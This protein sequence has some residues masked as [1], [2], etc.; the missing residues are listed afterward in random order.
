MSVRVHASCV[1]LGDRGVLLTGAAGAGKSTAALRL[2]ALGAE[3]VADDQVILEARDG[4]LVA[5]APEATAG[6]IEARGVG[7]LSLPHRDR[8]A[9]AVVVDLD[10]IESRR[11][12]PGRE[13][14]IEDVRLPLVHGRDLPDLAA[15]LVAWLARGGGLEEP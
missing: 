8:V 13:A 10:T 5:S 15:V 14:E 2:I 11:L 12:P 3:L 1:A 9:L 6:R 4:A 7:I